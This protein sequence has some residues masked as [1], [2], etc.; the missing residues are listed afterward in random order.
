MDPLSKQGANAPAQAM[1]MMMATLDPKE[2]EK[3]IA[4]LKT[5]Q[6]WLNAQVG[7]VEMTIKTLEYQHA[8]LTSSAT[9]KT[10]SA[11]APEAAITNP[12]AWAWSLMQQP[13]A[14]PASTP[15][16]AKKAS[17]STPKRAKK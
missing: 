7:M 15:N 14:A 11:V 8:L 2:I 17:K 3:K 9:G 16:A 13:F 1:Q 10:A 12:A 6:A 4:E 5:V